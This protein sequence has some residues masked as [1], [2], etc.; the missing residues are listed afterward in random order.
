MN[1]KSRVLHFSQLPSV[2]RGGGVKTTL[3]VGKAIADVDLTTGVTSFP[4]G[5]AVPLHQHNCAEQ[6][7]ILEGEAEVEIDGEAHRLGPFDTT[8]VPAGIPHRFKNAGP[9]RMSILWIYASAEVTRTFTET[10]QTVPH[11]SAAD[12]GATGC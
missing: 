4:P 7:T 1:R 12:T 5:A 10:G 2:S 11:L 9:S 8:F 3:L 6:V